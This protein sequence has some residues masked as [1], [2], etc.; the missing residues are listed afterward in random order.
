VIVTPVP[1]NCAS[2]TPLPITPVA[3]YPNAV[4]K[5]GNNGSINCNQFCSG[6]QYGGFTGFCIDGYDN[7]NKKYIK[8]D[9]TNP[10]N[11]VSCYC[12]LEPDDYYVKTTNDGSVTC[13]QFCAGSQWGDSGWCIGGVNTT[14]NSAQQCSASVGS[15]TTLYNAY[16]AYTS[17]TN[18]SCYCK[19]AHTPDFTPTSPPTTSFWKLGNNG[20]VGC[21]EFCTNSTYG[22][23]GGMCIG[24]Y[25]NVNKTYIGCNS[26]SSNVNVNNQNI[27]CYCS[28]VTP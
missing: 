19:K 1:T 14:N 9:V 17:N 24:G 26:N 21:D 4:W 6:I 10:S 27:S 13:D 20:G 2:P 23:K 16:G 5:Q 18:M 3:E 22:G 15:K 25:D 12:N 28:P 8:C 7:V 11:S